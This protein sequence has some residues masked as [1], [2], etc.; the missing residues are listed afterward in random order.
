MACRYECHKPES[1]LAHGARPASLGRMAKLFHPTTRRQTRLGRTDSIIG[2]TTVGI[3]RPPW[4]WKRYL[5]VNGVQVAWLGNGCDTCGFMFEQCGAPTP[6]V[7][8]EALQANF[9]RSLVQLDNGVIDTVGSLLPEGE[10]VVALLRCLPIRVEPGGPGDYFFEELTSASNPYVLPGEDMFEPY[11]ETNTHYYRLFGRSGLSVGKDPN[12]YGGT[13]F[14]FIMPLAQAIDP[15]TVATYRE[16]MEAGRAP[17]AVSLSVLDISALTYGDPH[18]CMA[19]CLI[20][21]HHKV[22]AAAEAQKPLTLLAF[23][24]LEAGVSSKEDVLHFL[25]TY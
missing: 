17:T 1:R 24:S 9:T 2:L 6:I 18:W 4:E 11:A 23:I 16:L 22:A 3:T 21:G 8:L 12:E 15:D 5:T 19:H 25:S 7:G 13:R 10:Y 20:D 14:D